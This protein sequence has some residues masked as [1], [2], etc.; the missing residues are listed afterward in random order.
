MECLFMIFAKYHQMELL[1]I[2]QPKLF[3]ETV[4]QNGKIRKIYMNA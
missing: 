1:S 2:F 3:S 4:E